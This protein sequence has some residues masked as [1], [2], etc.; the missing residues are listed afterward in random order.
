MIGD[1]FAMQDSPLS[2]SILG[3]SEDLPIVQTVQAVQ[4]VSV[5]SDD[6]N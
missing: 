3:Y 1:V 2:D 5:S 4:F 6:L